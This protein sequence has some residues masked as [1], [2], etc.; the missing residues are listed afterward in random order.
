MMISASRKRS[1]SYVLI[2]WSRESPTKMSLPHIS[3][4][5]STDSIDADLSMMPV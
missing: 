3:T 1:P 4:G 5:E 2:P